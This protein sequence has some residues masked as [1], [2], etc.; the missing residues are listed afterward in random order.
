VDQGC[1]HGKT[2][3]ATDGSEDRG[4]SWEPRNMDNLSELVKAR[5]LVL[6]SSLPRG[7]QACILHELI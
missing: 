3:L 2:Q 5:K 7:K 1:D 4:S 6:L